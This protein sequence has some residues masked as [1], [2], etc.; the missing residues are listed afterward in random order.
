MKELP[1]S[2][3]G[4]SLDSDGAGRQGERYAAL[5]QTVERLER[6]GLRLSARFGPDL[7]EP[8]LRE[9]IEVER[10]CCS[11]FAIDYEPSARV[12]TLSVPDAAHAPAL[13]AIEAALA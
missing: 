9:T 3:I 6:D 11:F 10:G 1:L 4:C 7:D 8:L 13:E 12:L 2:G 5:G